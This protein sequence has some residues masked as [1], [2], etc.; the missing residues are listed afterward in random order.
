MRKILLIALA[1]VFTQLISS[2][3][4]L[5]DRPYWGPDPDKSNPA[6][7]MVY[8][9]SRDGY[10]NI[11][12]TQLEIFSPTDNPTIRIYGKNLC[13]RDR[14]GVGREEFYDRAFGR[15]WEGE[16][17]S[18][19]PVTSYS[20]YNEGTGWREIM[21]GAWDHRR[22]DCNDDFTAPISLG[23]GRWDPEVRMFRFDFRAQA[24][25]T[26]SS[27]Y[28]INSFR[29]VLTAADGVISQDPNYDARSI[30]MQ[31]GRNALRDDEGYIDHA[32]PFA[33]P[34]NGRAERPEILIY[35]DDLNDPGIQPNGRLGVR[36][37]REHKTTRVIDY[38]NLVFTTDRGRITYD[39]GP[40][41]F[42]TLRR[43]A[44]GSGATIGVAFNATPAYRYT[45]ELRDIYSNN[46]V[47]LYIPYSKITYYV[48]CSSDPAC[49]AGPCAPG[50]S[51]EPLVSATPSTPTVFGQNIRFDF[52][53]RRSSASGGP[54]SVTPDRSVWLDQNGN[55][56]R[57]GGEP[58]A[59]G[60]FSTAGAPIATTTARTYSAGFWAPGGARPACVGPAAPSMGAQICATS[61]V[62]AITS[63]AVPP[64]NFTRLPPKTVCIKLGKK[65]Y[66]S[67]R[68]GNISAGGRIATA[69]CS[70]PGR[71]QGSNF[72]ISAGG[73][74]GA[75]SDVG[76]KNIIGP[77]MTTGS[78]GD[79]ADT[80][81]HFA[82]T[83]SPEG[84]FGGQYCLTDGDM[85][86]P[87]T[88]KPAVIASPVTGKVHYQS[89]TTTLT[90]NIVYAE[91]PNP[92]AV[93]Q[94]VLRVNGDLR[95]SAGVTRLDGIYIVTG[96]LYTCDQ[97]TGPSPTNLT[98]TAPCNTPLTINGALIIGGEVFARRTFGA[99]TGAGQ[100]YNMPAETF[101]LHPH[102]LIS[103]YERDSASGAL[104][105]VREREVPP[106]N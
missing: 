92:A 38:S 97:G 37:R 52:N 72:T 3:I 73:T 47:Q 104:R 75:Y 79:I 26:P 16:R 53:I 39:R 91:A 106:R 90:N 85:F 65:P 36:L 64:P 58:D 25:A 22:S 89:G 81:L 82:N 95:I 99:V 24:L 12:R 57:E 2:G 4:A 18:G 46:T 87:Y 70:Q 102:S 17:P 34:C 8:L 93:P 15:K 29:L 67:S 74:F 44:G 11:S 98:L 55:G 10:T 33:Q 49:P 101:N 5:A 27:G 43:V 35:D 60:C 66:F 30:G 96:N 69:G 61:A 68:N 41:G 21:V 63:P 31:Y 9:V 76:L 48:E 45:L 6:G 40:D 105:T 100:S 56:T 59:G 80:T 84:N 54:A 42:Y 62:G 77:I 19:T 88:P 14:T 13:S 1:A 86:A 94:L 20:I 28:Y 83:V 51:F 7:Y 71:I 32:V 103:E 78:L 23:R 50:A